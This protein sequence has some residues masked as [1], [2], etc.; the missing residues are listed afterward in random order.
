MNCTLAIK[1]QYAFHDWVVRLLEMHALFLGWHPTHHCT[2]HQIRIVTLWKVS[3]IP[4]LFCMFQLLIIF[5]LVAKRS[6]K[7]TMPYASFPASKF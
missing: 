5:P 7:Q 1:T 2:Q 3:P 6:Q 4:I